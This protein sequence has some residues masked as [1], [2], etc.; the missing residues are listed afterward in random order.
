MSVRRCQREVDS[1][2]FA[3][4]KGMQKLEPYGD[5]WR[6]AAIVAWIIAR[7]N[8][9]RSRKVK[10]EDFM[11]DLYKPELG[12]SELAQKTTMIFAGLKKLKDKKR[13]GN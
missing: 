5:E 13:G 8:T 2:E 10:V 12:K 6:Q 1:V 11:P 9:K 4:W 3:E 7:V